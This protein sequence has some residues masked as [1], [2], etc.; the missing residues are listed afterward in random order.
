MGILSRIIGKIAGKAE[1][2]AAD[3]RAELEAKAAEAAAARQATVEELRAEGIRVI[4]ALNAEKARAKAK[5]QR[6]AIA[7]VVAGLCAVGAALWFWLA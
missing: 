3:A 5:A 4:E 1:A 2:E 7:A 6:Y